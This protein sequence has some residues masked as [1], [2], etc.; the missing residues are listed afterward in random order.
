MYSCWPNI[1][2]VSSTPWNDILEPF[3]TTLLSSSSVVHTPFNTGQWIS[4]NNGVFIEE[5]I[6][7]ALNDALLQCN[8]NIVKVNNNCAHSLQVY[9]K[10]AL[11]KLT[12]TFA[13]THLKYSLYSYKHMSSNNKITIL[14]YCLSDKAYSNIIDLELLP[15]ADGTFQKFQHSGRSVPSICVLKIILSIYCLV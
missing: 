6:P 7:Q 12:P 13:R 8:V 10:N 2:K 9:Y 11:S 15:L 1:K 5:E 4:V 3:Y 14:K